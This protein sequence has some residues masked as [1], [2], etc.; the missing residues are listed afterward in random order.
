MLQQSGPYITA[1]KCQKLDTRK[2]ETTLN[3]NEGG[4]HMARANS[5]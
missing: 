1:D 2:E 3:P 5:I 4:R